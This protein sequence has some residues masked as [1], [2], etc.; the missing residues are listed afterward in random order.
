MA[1]KLGDTLRL[2][3]AVS[4][5]ALL[6]LGASA[7]RSENGGADVDIDTRVVN[8]IPVD[9]AAYPWF[10]VLK[11]NGRLFCGGSLIS[12]NHVLTA[13]HCWLNSQGTQ[14]EVNID[15]VTTTSQCN[16]LDDCGPLS[17]ESR[18]TNVIVHSQ[19][20]FFLSLFWHLSH[21]RKI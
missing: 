8:G 20:A 2:I 9:P 17:V 10:T 3:L 14:I 15:G 18:V 11:R 6:V 7:T 21:V 4:A 13:A 19:Y 1:R 16:Q 12:P 5:A